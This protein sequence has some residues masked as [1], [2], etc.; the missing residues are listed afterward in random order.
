M[1]STPLIG[2]TCAVC[3][4]DTPSLTREEAEGLMTQTPNWMLSDDGRMIHRSFIFKNFR[5][6]LAFVNRVSAVADL[7]DHH[8]DVHWSWNKLT[9]E[10]TTHAIRGL[11]KNDFILAAKI[12]ALL[13]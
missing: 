2:Q 4:G 8:P 6:V 13:F 5:E 12:D 9:L 10:I 11:S 1:E 7:E 3:R